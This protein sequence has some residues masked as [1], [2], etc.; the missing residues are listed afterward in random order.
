M[1]AQVQESMIY[2]SHNHPSINKMQIVAHTISYI[3][4]SWQTE[5]PI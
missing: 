5:R 4:T 3:N 1:H 2:L